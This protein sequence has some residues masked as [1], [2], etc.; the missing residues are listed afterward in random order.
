MWIS[1]G[2]IGRDASLKT[3]QQGRFGALTLTQVPSLKITY[4]SKMARDP[5]NTV[6]LLQL[7][8][9]SVQEESSKWIWDKSE[10]N[11]NSSIF[12]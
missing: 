2:K 1:Y 6:P 7:L 12:I 8:K 9:E 10:D 4:T 11:E 5:E 3:W